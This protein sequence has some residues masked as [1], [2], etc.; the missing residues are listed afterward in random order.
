[1]LRCSSA[2]ALGGSGMPSGVRTVA[3]RSAAWRRVG[4]KLRI[5]SRARVPF[6]RLTNRVR[7]PTRHSRSRV[8]R[9]ASSS[10]I[11]GTRAMLQWPRSPRSHPKNPRLSNS[12]SSRSVFA[13]RCSRDTATLE[14]WIACAST[15]RTASQ[16]ASQKP[17]RPAG[18][19][20]PR[21]LFT[22]PDRLIPP[23]MQ[24]GKQ[25][26][27]ARFQ[28]LARLTLNAGNHP[29]DQPTRLAQLDDGN[30]RAIVVQGDEGPAQVIR[31]GHCGT[32]S[33]RAKRRSC[34]VLG[35]RPIASSSGTAAQKPWISQHSG[36]GGDRRD[37]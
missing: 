16:R 18:K 21:D 13:R 24:Q 6:M 11:V 17:S 5:P 35:A 7:S 10:A 9:L 36:H 27:W 4:L 31:L 15:P 2:K 32:P 26:F 20:N 19:C 28:L 8:G 14:G 29:A 30:D 25:P 37:S 1:M 23:V 3:R 12:V 22:G 33:V 34:H